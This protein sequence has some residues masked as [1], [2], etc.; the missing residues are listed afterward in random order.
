MAIKSVIMSAEDIQKILDGRKTCMRRVVR[1]LPER[2]Y[3]VEAEVPDGGKP[4]FICYYGGYVESINGFADFSVSI[5]PPCQPGDILCVRKTM[6]AY[7]YGEKESGELWLK[8]TD[9]CIERLQDITD[10]EAKAEGSNF[11]DGKN[12]GWEE[13][14]RRTAVERFA[15]NWDSTIKES[16]IKEYGWAANPWI[17]AV[18]FEQCERP[19][20]A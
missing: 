7:L 2:T 18:E 20:D 12:V 11:K 9:I 15:E 3:R 16:E 10:E 14:M 17:V 6:R 13:K 8:V 1:G 4:R 19:E 5:E